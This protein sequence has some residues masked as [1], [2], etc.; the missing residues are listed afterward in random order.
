MINKF[1]ERYDHVVRHGRKEKMIAGGMPA[2]TFLS[3]ADTFIEYAFERACAQLKEGMVTLNEWRS[4]KE[5]YIRLTETTIYDFEHFSRHDASHSI[6][7]LETIVMVVGVDRIVQLSRGD[8]WLLLEAAYSHDI[9]MAMTGDELCELWKN[10]EFQKYLLNCLHSSEIG[11]REAAKF[12]HQMDNLIH[13]KDQMNGMEGQQTIVFEECWPVRISNYVEWL[14]TG[15]IRRNHAARNKKVRARII[16]LKDTSIP[17]RLYDAVVHISGLHTQDFEKIFEELPREMKGIGEELVHPQFTAAMLRL[18]DVLDVENNRFSIYALEHMLEVPP[19]SMV[20]YGKHK[21]IRTIQ[22]T[23]KKIDLTAESEQLQV[24]R[25][26]SQWFD[27]VDKEVNHVIAY[28]NNIA[29]KRLRGCRL[30][31]SKCTVYRIIQNGQR[32]EKLEYRTGDQR[33][34]DIQKEKFLKL[35][36]GL[37]IYKKYEFIRE[38]MQNALDASKVQ[39]WMDLKRHLYDEVLMK[40]DMEE[41]MPY[42]IPKSVY[43]KYGVEVRIELNES[44]GDADEDA[45]SGH[46]HHYRRAQLIIEDK[47][48]GMEKECL[49][50]IS[51][52]GAGWKKRERYRNELGE[53]PRWLRPTGGFG[54]GLQSAFMVSDRVEIETRAQSGDEGGRRIIMRKQETGNIIESEECHKDDRGTKITIDVPISEL[55]NWNVNLGENTSKEGASY[56]EKQH[57]DYNE[58]FSVDHLGEYILNVITEYLSKVIPDSVLPI[59]IRM[60]GFGH[61][62]L[63]GKLWK[64]F[65]LREENEKNAEQDKCDEIDWEGRS[66]QVFSA[67]DKGVCIW[68]KANETFVDLGWGKPNGKDSAKGVVCYKGI[69]MA[70]TGILDQPIYQGFVM[71][72]DYMGLDAGQ[73]LQLNR[74]EFT[75]EAEKRH[76]GYVKQYIQIFMH[77]LTLYHEKKEME[78]LFRLSYESVPEFVLSRILLSAKEDWDSLEKEVAKLCKGEK[79]DTYVIG[80]KQLLK[81]DPAE[82]PDG[83]AAEKEF[84][85]RYGERNGIANRGVDFLEFMQD[86]QNFV[87]DETDSEMLLLDGWYDMRDVGRSLESDDVSLTTPSLRDAISEM[88]QDKN[89]EDRKKD[90]MY[91]SKLMIEGAYVCPE[92][93]Q[94][95]HTEEAYE[96]I[97]IRMQIDKDKNQWLFVTV[98]KKRKYIRKV[99][100][101]FYLHSYT[102]DGKEG[103]KV[104]K[105]A[106]CPKELANLMV[107]GLPWQKG[108]LGEDHVLISPIPGAFRRRMEGKRYRNKREYQ[109]TLEWERFKTELTSMEEFSFLISYVTDSTLNQELKGNAEEVQKQ[110]L[111]YAKEIWKVVFEQG[112]ADSGNEER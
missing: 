74:N 17:G 92:L 64:S 24:C 59:T 33:H 51:C 60:K 63:E 18:G 75:P 99:A 38:Y 89:T 32:E 13:R 112:R 9:G 66:Y 98:F 5:Q 95:L 102:N 70:R 25:E 62:N 80:K 72:I 93:L 55:L 7:I 10:K 26:T 57:S 91:I 84:S 30:R 94:K 69:R 108:S 79:K 104:W 48:I 27:L 22:I 6:S 45:K 41:L 58:M 56:L 15:Y 19:L 3:E 90:K 52:I 39:I 53:M 34:F 36:E 87:S 81:E 88:E 109:N 35:V 71:L 8:L 68:D 44:E 100:K 31:P 82:S 54:I 2:N 97:P 103:R 21:A 47:G 73:D 20:H 101:N 37:N 65:K 77:L 96:E 111:A 1:S 105:E 67:E 29:P 85:L 106:E 50:V 4:H 76:R 107:G 86:Y 49:D 46:S 11:E 12:Y 61:K 110:Y 78:K 40:H 14:T 42:D 83:E 43:E 16:T 23:S 28:W